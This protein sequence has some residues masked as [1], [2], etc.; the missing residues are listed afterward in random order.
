MDTLRLHQGERV[1]NRKSDSISRRSMLAGMAAGSLVTASAVAQEQTGDA[2]PASR[3]PGGSNPGLKNPA[4]A[5]Q[6][7]DMISAA[8]PYQKQRRRVLGREMAFVEVGA[9]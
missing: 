9:G 8:F 2:G 4:R 3:A 7:L 5:S 1:M 6:N